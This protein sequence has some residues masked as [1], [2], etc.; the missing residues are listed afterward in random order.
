MTTW[1]RSDCKAR[2]IAQIRRNCAREKRGK[3]RERER[4][5]GKVFKGL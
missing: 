4:E 1:H 3:R 2:D 5:A